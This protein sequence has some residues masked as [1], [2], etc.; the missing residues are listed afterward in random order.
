QQGLAKLS[1]NGMST[2]ALHGLPS[3]LFRIMRLFPR[4]TPILM[5]DGHAAWRQEIYPEYK[6]NRNLD[7]ETVQLKEAY[8]AQG[9]YLRQLILKLGIPQIADPEAEADDIAGLIVRNAPGDL[10]ILM[11]TT[12]MDWVQ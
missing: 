1:K 7:P 6:I 8:K 2:A 10:N 11:V 9:P 3:S 4:A 12:D 5:W